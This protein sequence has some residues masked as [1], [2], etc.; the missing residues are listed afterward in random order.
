M[1]GSNNCL[2]YAV[3]RIEPFSFADWVTIPEK[4]SKN[5]CALT[6]YILMGIL[7]IVAASYEK[8]NAFLLFSENCQE[9]LRMRDV[10]RRR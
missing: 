6:P 10:L 2:K 3:G 4:V 8:C 9:V 5:I 1:D 7:D